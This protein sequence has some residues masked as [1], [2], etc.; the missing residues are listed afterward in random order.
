ML[1]TIYKNYGVLSAE[2]RSIYT[3]GAP[4]TSAICS[5]II[6]VQLPENSFFSVYTTV[7]NDLAVESSWGGVYSINDVLQGDE[8]PCFFAIDNDGNGHRVYLEEIV[9]EN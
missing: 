1:I 8:K 4:E 7:M 9:E 6:N 3:Y 2:K 5:D